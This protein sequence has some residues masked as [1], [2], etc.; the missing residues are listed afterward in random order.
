MKHSL[1]IHPIMRRLSESRPVFHAEADFQHALA[2]AIHATFPDSRVR[3]EFN[4]F[5]QDDRRSYLDIWLA[6]TGVAL[7]LKYKTR[8]L[9]TEIDE[10]RFDLRD[11]SA[12]NHGRYDFL[13][14]VQRL[15]RIVNEGKARAGCAVMLTNDSYYWRAPRPSYPEP[16]YA[17]FRIHEGRRV[18][19]EL[20]WNRQS[21]GTKGRESPIRLTGDYAMRWQDYSNLESATNVAFR[22]L[23][24][25]VAPSA[26]GRG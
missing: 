17:A 8:A 26:N 12:Q 1:D 21:G 19:G 9:T 13:R 6:D 18:R 10:E 3:L 23:A 4:P 11:Q 2:W 25:A 5:A 22:Y 24:V 20:K 15:E 7:E 14:D 16:S